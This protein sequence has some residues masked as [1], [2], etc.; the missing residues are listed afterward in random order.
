VR[1]VPHDADRERTSGE[2]ILDSGI[3]GDASMRDLGLYHRAHDVP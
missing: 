1:G 3:L 2:C